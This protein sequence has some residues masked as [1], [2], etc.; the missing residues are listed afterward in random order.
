MGMGDRASA[1]TKI[2]KLL[3][4]SKSAND[5]DIVLW[6]VRNVPERYIRI[7]CATPAGTANGT[8]A[9]YIQYGPDTRPITNAVANSVLVETIIAGSTGTA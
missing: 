7:Y 9:E 6:D 4:L 1:I 5:N 3:A 8:S 2:W